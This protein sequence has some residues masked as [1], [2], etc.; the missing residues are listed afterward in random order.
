MPIELLKSILS[1][2]MI[3]IAFVQMFIMFELFGR[4]PV[5]FDAA[6]LKRFHRINGIVFILLYFFIAYFC[7][8]YIISTKLEPSPRVTF[9]AVIAFSVIIL[10]F[11]K[12]AF[13]RFYRQFYEKVLTLGPLIALLAFG[14]MA[15][16]G[17]Y[18]FLVT[19]F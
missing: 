18:Y 5:R 8:E 3:A 13:V 7:L 2:L 14:M 16:S 19:L 9:H 10:L 15:T 1:S 11:L 4:D 17:G 12:I 6:T